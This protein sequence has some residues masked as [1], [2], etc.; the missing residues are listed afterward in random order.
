MST[1]QVEDDIKKELFAV[2]A[3]L[4]SKLGRRVSLSE[5]V[6]VLLETYRANERDMAKM[7]S[8]FGCLG[9]ASEG[10]KLL[11]EIRAEEEKSLEHLTRKHNA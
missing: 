3:E 10:K 8:L 2:A 6:R 1:V 4:Q 5:A 7:L 9:P 11:G